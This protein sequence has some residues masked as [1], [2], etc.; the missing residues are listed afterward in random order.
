MAACLAER[1]TDQIA[2]PVTLPL[3]DNLLGVRPYLIAGD[4]REV[5]LESPQQSLR[6]IGV[7]VWFELRAQRVLTAQNPFFKYIFFQQVFHYLSHC[8]E[9]VQGLVIGASLR[10]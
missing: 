1:L 10:V 5:G 6:G 3:L 9:M 4:M 8:F 2:P 7:Q